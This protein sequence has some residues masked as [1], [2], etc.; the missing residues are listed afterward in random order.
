M[1]AL[2]VNSAC[3]LPK[4]RGALHPPDPKRSGGGPGVVSAYSGR[5]YNV[6]HK[7]FSRRWAQIRARPVLVKL[8]RHFRCNRARRPAGLWAVLGLIRVAVIDLLPG[9]GAQCRSLP[10]A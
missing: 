6:T 8:R 10:V 9:Y 2:P 5:S 1:P 4:L 7:T 3:L